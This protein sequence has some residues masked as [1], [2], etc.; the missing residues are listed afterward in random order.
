MGEW[1]GQKT[2]GDTVNNTQIQRERGKVT[3]DRWKGSVNEYELSDVKV[4]MRSKR[5][6]DAEPQTPGFTSHTEAFSRRLVWCGLKT[7]LLHG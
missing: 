1:I 5:R 2:A 6:K 4:R 7:G 3:W